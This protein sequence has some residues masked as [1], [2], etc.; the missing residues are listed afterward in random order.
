MENDPN[1]LSAV[2]L[3]MKNCLAMNVIC[4]VQSEK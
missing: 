3:K 1:R 4:W 2:L